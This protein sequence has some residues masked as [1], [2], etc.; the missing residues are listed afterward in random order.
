MKDKVTVKMRQCDRELSALPP[1]V[2]ADPVG[3]TIALVTSFSQLIAEHVSGSTT[4]VTLVQKNNIAY[5]NYKTEIGQTAPKFVPFQSRRNTYGVSEEDQDDSGVDLDDIRA[6]IASYV[7][8]D[9]CPDVGAHC[10][11]S[12]QVRHARVASPRPVRRLGVAHSKLPG[13]LGVLY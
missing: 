9:P 8:S 4:L 12:V 10:A 11:P 3:H 13:D 2:T 5:D 7:L 6:H 1:V